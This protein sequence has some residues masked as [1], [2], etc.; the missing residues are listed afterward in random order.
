M[1]PRLPL[2]GGVNVTA[3]PLQMALITFSLM[4]T[5]L[6]GSRAVL[7]PLYL[8]PLDPAGFPSPVQLP[9]GRL[10]VSS[11]AAWKFVSKNWT[12]PPAAVGS[13]PPVG[14]G[15]RLPVGIGLETSF[16]RVAGL[17]RPIFPGIGSS[18]AWADPVAIPRATMVK[19]A[20]LAAPL[21]MQNPPS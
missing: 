13:S 1:T 16:A 3:D 5:T 9:A 20:I 6:Q 21:S 2:K 14:S 19:N 18:T 11:P 7:V 17:M 8:K 12:L 10:Y 15:N 4:R